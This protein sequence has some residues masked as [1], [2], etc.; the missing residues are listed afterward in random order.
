MKYSKKY[1]DKD[2]NLSP[3][4]ALEVVRGFGVASVPVPET[5]RADMGDVIFYLGYNLVNSGRTTENGEPLFVN[6]GSVTEENIGKL[7]I[8]AQVLGN[9]EAIVAQNVY[10]KKKCDEMYQQLNPKTEKRKIW[11]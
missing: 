5:E 7:F 1:L 2:G 9:V 3:E 6:L 11:S 8:L 4:K 10:L